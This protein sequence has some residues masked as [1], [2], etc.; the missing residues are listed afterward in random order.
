MKVAVIHN[1]RAGGARR[2]LSEQLT[3]LEG[4]VVEL[5]LQGAAPVT[6]D[7]VVI[8]WRE[9]APTLAPPLRPP[10]RYA[11]LAGLLRAWRGVAD[12]L[13]RL[14]PDVVFANPCWRL[15]API[16]LRSAGVPSLYY[17]DE[18]RRVNHEPPARASRRTLTRPVYG[19]LYAVERR[20]DAAAAAAATMLATNSRHTARGIRM[21]Y[22]REAHIVPCGVA[23]RFLVSA[24][25]APA[26]FVLS[27]GQL[28][29]SKGHELVVA[30]AARTRRRWPVVVIAPR[31][32]DEESRRLRALAA[33]ASVPLEIRVDV[34]DD[35]L[36]EAYRAAVA[37]L[38]LSV[39][40]PFG[41]ASLEAQA[42]GCPV[43]V[44]DEGGLPETL[45][46]GC[47][48]WT[49][50]RSADA[51]AER[52]DALEEEGVRRR[53]GD[54]ARAWAAKWTWRRSGAAVSA[55]LAELAG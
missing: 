36:F 28:I 53:I 30:A 42:V 26:R 7:A 29:P 21:A 6:N 12:A 2:R 3:H 52:I 45:R 41:L 31:P 13:E 4:D 22:G 10:L 19:P 55:L 37:T 14:R 51:A 24:A 17:C 11:D 49:V 18:P 38:Y 1:L 50:P 25:P 27:V 23:D 33:A 47:T 5:T 16:A 39:R 8:P 32:N 54:A 9:V 46:A 44:A 15:Q 20:L 43:I 34:G 40:E 35:E 48:G